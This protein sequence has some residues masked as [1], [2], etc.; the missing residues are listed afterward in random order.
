MKITKK[1]VNVNNKRLHADIDAAIHDCLRMPAKW[2][3]QAQRDAMIDVIK[4]KLAEFIDANEITQ[5]KVIGDQRNNKRKDLAEGVVLV[6]IQY[7][8]RNCLNVTKLWYSIDSVEKKKSNYTITEAMDQFF[9][10]INP[11]P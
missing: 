3:N 10:S 9:K 5:F 8:Q 4:E 7:K 1:T 11:R 2:H 6:E